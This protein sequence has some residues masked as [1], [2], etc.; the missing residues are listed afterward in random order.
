MLCCWPHYAITQALPRHPLL[1][2]W[3]WRWHVQVGLRGAGKSTILRKLRLS[4]KLESA[5]A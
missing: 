3:R 5:G 4:D 2:R 1:L